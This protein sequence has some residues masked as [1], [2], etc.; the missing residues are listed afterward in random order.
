MTD[1]FIALEAYLGPDICSE[2]GLCIPESTRFSSK[3]GKLSHRKPIANAKTCALCQDFATDALSYLDRNT[4]KAKIIGALH[5][6]CSRLE[7]ISKQVGDGFHCHVDFY[8]SSCRIFCGIL[9][10]VSMKF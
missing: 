5:V 6:A 10:S 7:E 8:S 2:A 4:T 9:C 1:A 3:R